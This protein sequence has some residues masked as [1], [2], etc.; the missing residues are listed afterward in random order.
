MDSTRHMIEEE[1]SK[2][3]LSFLIEVLNRDNNIYLF[4]E[5]NKLGVGYH[6]YQFLF[7]LYHEKTAIQEE[8]A[9]RFK[10][11]EST[12]TRALKKLEDKDLIKREQDENNRRRNIVSLKKKGIKTVEQ[13]QKADKIWEKEILSA[14][15]SEERIK[16][17]KALKKIAI[18]SFEI[19]EEIRMNEFHE[20][21]KDRLI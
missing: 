4:F 1:P 13:I 8:L 21:T 6:E 18:S 17:K 10:K 11:N 20:K 14:L 15:S 12:I 9:K 5:M 16:I 3:S 19:R 2:I 7:Y